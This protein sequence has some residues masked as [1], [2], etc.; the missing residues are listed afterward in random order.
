M[1]VEL[2]RHDKLA[3]RQGS[4]CLI[5]RGERDALHFAHV[6][7]RAGFRV[8]RLKERIRTNLIEWNPNQLPYAAVV[9]KN[10]I[11]RYAAS[12]TSPYS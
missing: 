11:R 4:R 3:D 1:G 8:R 7:W 5:V 9:R 12:F 2:L 10:K 6:E